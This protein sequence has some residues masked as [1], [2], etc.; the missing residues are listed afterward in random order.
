MYM[1]T[2]GSSEGAYLNIP[3]RPPGKPSPH[4]SY[5]QQ[6]AGTCTWIQLGPGLGLRIWMSQAGLP[7]CSCVTLLTQ[8]AGTCTWTHGA[9]ARVPI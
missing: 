1:D 8:Q 5:L 6:Q 9:Q 3:G 4:S 7:V 2:R